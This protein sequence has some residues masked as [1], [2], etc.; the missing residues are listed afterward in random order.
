M[1]IPQSSTNHNQQVPLFR[2]SESDSESGIALKLHE[3]QRECLDKVL[4]D[5]TI[6][7]FILY[8]VRLEFT[9]DERADYENM[10]EILSLFLASL[11]KNIIPQEANVLPF[12]LPTSFCCSISNCLGC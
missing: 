6:S 1:I 3:W 5:R 11:M 4:R 2:N 8:S 10:N 7:R 12:C 9:T